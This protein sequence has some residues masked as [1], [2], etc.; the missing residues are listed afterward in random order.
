MNTL[1]PNTPRKGLNEESWRRLAMRAATAVLEEEEDLREQYARAERE[2]VF[3]GCGLYMNF[4]GIPE[5]MR[6]VG[7]PDRVVSRLVGSV[8]GMKGA[9]FFDVFIR[10]GMLACLEVSSTFDW[11]PD[12]AASVVLEKGRYVG[13]EGAVRW[14]R[15]EGIV[16]ENQG[17]SPMKVPEAD[18]GLHAAEG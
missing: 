14:F 4:K 15:A 2:F 11:L 10:D 13:E 7:R 17:N 6:L 12:S 8:P 18:A 5:E 1:K 16:R 9:L 3:T